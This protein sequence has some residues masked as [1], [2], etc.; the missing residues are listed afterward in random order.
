SVHSPIED[1]IKPF[2]QKH[3]DNYFISFSLAQRT[4]LPELNWYANI[5][6]GVDTNV[7]TFDPE[8]EDYFLYL[9]RITADKGVHLAIEAA[10]LAGVNLRIAG[11]SYPAEGYWQKHIEPE[12]NGDTVRYFGEVSFESKIPLLQ[13]ARG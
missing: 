7:F 8:P 12:V 13:K 1:R 5:Y 3:K 10:K 6:H 4:Q 2:L 11:S 9:G